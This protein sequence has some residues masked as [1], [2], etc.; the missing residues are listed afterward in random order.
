MIG[1]VPDLIRQ[2]LPST[3]F[4]LFLRTPSEVLSGED[5]SMDPTRTSLPKSRSPTS[6]EK[7]LSKKLMSA[8][9]TSLPSGRI[10]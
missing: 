9:A 2:R 7:A 3:I 4:H 10:Q 1:I 8:Q 5:R 6:S